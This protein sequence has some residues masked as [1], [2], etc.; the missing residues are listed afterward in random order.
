MTE[1]TSNK[2]D[3]SASVEDTVFIVSPN[4][5]LIDGLRTFCASRDMNLWIGDPDSP[6]VIAV[7]Y[8]VGIVDKYFMD[9]KSWSDWL[10]FLRETKGFSHEHLLIIVLPYP[11]SEVALEAAKREFEDAHE[12]VSFAFGPDWSQVI[13]SI[14]NWLDTG[15]R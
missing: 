6:D 12:P 3:G 2:E 7:P 9:E 13:K 15:L 5:Q 14:E 4:T 11:F 8:K 1:T 10:E